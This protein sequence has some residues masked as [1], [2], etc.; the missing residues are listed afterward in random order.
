MCYPHFANFLNFQLKIKILRNSIVFPN[1]LDDSRDSMCLTHVPL[2]LPKNLNFQQKYIE[3][4]ILLRFSVIFKQKFSKVG[5]R[6][7][8]QTPSW[9]QSKR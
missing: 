6:F 8:H 5:V 3:S 2:F 1:F 4:K 9:R 7:S